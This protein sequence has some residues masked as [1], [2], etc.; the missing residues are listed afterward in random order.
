[1]VQQFLPI[2]KEGVQLINQHVGYEKREGKIYYYV[3]QTILNFHDENDL[4]SFKCFT[5]QL[6]V[7]GNVKQSEIIRA[8]GVKKKTV[9]RAVK[10]YREEGIGSFF[11]ARNT[12]GGTILTEEVIIKIEQ[13]L[14]NGISVADI[15]K[16]KGIKKNTI[17][18][19]IRAGRIKK[20]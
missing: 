20:N 6:V 11:K 5:S 1:M 3:G 7:T 18:K 10:K 16:K 13:E 8:F 9:M 14:M 4:Q 19:A 17:E 15:A 12:R 2:Y